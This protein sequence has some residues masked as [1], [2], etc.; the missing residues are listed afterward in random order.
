M[1]YSLTEKLITKRQL[2]CLKCINNSFD[3]KFTLFILSILV[4]GS[5]FAHTIKLS[6][7]K[8]GGAI[9]SYLLYST[10]QVSDFSVN[11]VFD[12]GVNNDDAH[13]STLEV[14]GIAL[15]AVQELNDQNKKLKQENKDLKSKYESLEQRLLKLENLLNQVTTLTGN[16]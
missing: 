3:M 12:F 2:I 8:S 4:I 5:S 16:K 10:G 9:S 1:A 7:V 6:S 15:R 11:R 14:S 13:I